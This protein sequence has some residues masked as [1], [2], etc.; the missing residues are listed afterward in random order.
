MSEKINLKNAESISLTYYRRGL[1]NRINNILED[2]NTGNEIDFMIA[3]S[4]ILTG[5]LKEVKELDSI[6]ESRKGLNNGTK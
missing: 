6:L 3:D 5:M 2:L 4:M 1:I